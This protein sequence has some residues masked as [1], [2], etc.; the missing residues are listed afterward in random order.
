MRSLQP[1]SINSIGPIQRDT[2]YSRRALI[3]SSPAVWEMR[4]IQSSVMTCTNVIKLM[5]INLYA[6][7]RATLDGL[8]VLPPCGCVLHPAKSLRSLDKPGPRE[9][10]SH[11]WREHSKH[12]G[13]N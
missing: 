4:K 6:A 1:I 11:E 12:K 3:P 7:E 9:A 5:I 8:P 2:G 13:G 10:A